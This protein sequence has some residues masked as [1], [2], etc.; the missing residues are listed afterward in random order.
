[1]WFAK[2]QLIDK[3]RVGADRIP[4]LGHAPRSPRVPSR[5]PARRSTGRAARSACARCARPCP[6]GPRSIGCRGTPRASPARAGG[7]LTSGVTPLLNHCSTN[8]CVGCGGTSASVQLWHDCCH[9]KTP[10]G[11]PQRFQ[12]RKGRGSVCILF[13]SR[14]RAKGRDGF[15]E[16]TEAKRGC[17]PQQSAHRLFSGSASSA[18][19]RGS[20]PLKKVV[21]KTTKLTGKRSQP[22]FACPNELVIPAAVKAGGN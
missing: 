11:Q 9:E 8:T 7:V 21:V 12:H 18:F 2:P 10:P 1:M 14:K 4:R 15:A 17:S 22:D 6:G 19:S 20:I 3:S 5:R 16:R 13:G